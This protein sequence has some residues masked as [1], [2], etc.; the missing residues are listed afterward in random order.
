MGLR[1]EGEE[2]LVQGRAIAIGMAVASGFCAASMPSASAQGFFDFFFGRRPA[3]PPQVQP[4]A[5]PYAPGIGGDEPRGAEPGTPAASYCVRTCDGHYFPIP[6]QSGV[7]P[8][9]TCKSF[10]PAAETKIYSGGGIN[11]ATSPEGKRYSDLPN[12]YVYRDKIVDGCTCNGKSPFGLA[13]VNIGNDP[14]LQPGDI[15]ATKDGMATYGGERRGVAQF[16]PI[17]RSKVSSE[18]RSRL[19]QMRVQPEFDGEARQPAAQS[20]TTGVSPQD[21][22]RGRPSQSGR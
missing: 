6:R 19:S 20:E 11:Q 16:T 8:A 4:Y 21:E 10:C 3:P 14:T 22:R 12:A 2:V 15:V 18:M 13:R 7:T 1:R 9:Q 5:D 17:D